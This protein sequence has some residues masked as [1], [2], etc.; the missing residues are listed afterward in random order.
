MG[1]KSFHAYLV[2]KIKKWID[3]K[4][5]LSDF[6]VYEDSPSGTPYKIFNH[7]PDIYA[8]SHKNR[9]KIIGEAKAS[10]S[11]L[12][13]IRSRDQYLD[14]FEKC[15]LE[16]ET[17]LILAVPVDLVQCARSLIQA[18]KGVKYKGIKT[19]VLDIKD[20]AACKE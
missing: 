3:Y 10:R 7:V 15:L 5:G 17:V 6:V 12:E 16:Q 19:C 20:W 4:Y 11:D 14:Y 2:Q 18:L 8:T 13:S 9:L 1:E